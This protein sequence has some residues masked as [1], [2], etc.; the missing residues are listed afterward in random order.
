MN[1]KIGRFELLEQIDVGGYTTVYRATEDMGQGITR[2]A[3]VKA[4]QAW[5]LDDEDQLKRLKREVGVLIEIGDAPNI[6]SVHGMGI[7]EEMG[8]W[9]AM[10]LAGKSLK[11]SLS[12]KP[13]EPDQIRT[14]LS[15]VLHALQWVHGTEPPIL[16]RDLKPQNILRTGPGVWKVAD[17]GLA[18][19]AGAEETMTLATVKYAAPEL[20][21]SALGEE[22]PR[23]DIYA[24]GMIAY[25]MALGRA[26]FQKQFPSV[27]D[28]MAS[29]KDSEGDDR[30]KWMYWHTSMQM[31]LPPITELIEDYPQDLSDLIQKM[32]AK[33]IL[34]RIASA[35]E[36]LEQLGQVSVAKPLAMLDD[37]EDADKG[38]SLMKKLVGALAFLVVIAV[39]GGLMWKFIEGRPSIVFPDG[40]LFV[41]RSGV[42]QVTGRI[43]NF[44][45]TG[46]A[47]VRLKRGRPF[48]VSL[49]GSDGS[50]T[51]D[52]K[53]NELDT[54][55]GYLVVSSQT[56][57]TLA[58][59]PLQVVREAPETVRFELKTKP[60]VA[61]ATVSLRPSGGEQ[62]QITTDALGVANSVLPFGEF[63][64]ELFHPRY[65]PIARMT[66][67]TGIEPEWSDTADLKPRD[68][69]QIVADIQREIDRLMRLMKKKV[70]CPP[71]PPLTPEDEQQVLS[72]VDR[73]RQLA[74]GD[75]DIELFLESVG[76]TVDCEPSSMPVAPPLP[77]DPGAAGSF[78][79]SD[80]VGAL[81]RLLDRVERLIDRKVTCPPGPLSEFE[82][83]VLADTLIEIE[84][85]ALGDLDI[86]LYVDSVRSVVDC[87]P[88]SR[89]PRPEIPESLRQQLIAAAGGASGTSGRG[90]ADGTGGASGAGGTSGQAGYGGAAGRAGVAGAAANAVRNELDSFLN[91]SGQP[92][93][94]MRG[95]ASSADNGRAA[96]DSTIASVLAGMPPNPALVEYL[97]QTLT[98]E[99]FA[100]FIADNVPTG[101]I[102]I[103]ALTEVNKVRI[104]GPMFNTTDLEWMVKRL[105]YGWTR[106]QPEL[107]IDAWAVCRG[108]RQALESGGASGAR[109]DAYLIPDDP[110]MFVQ[111]EKTDSYDSTEAERIASTFT[112]DAGLIW[113]RGYIDAP[114]TELPEA[115][116]AEPE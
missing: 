109:V 100:E 31:V 102:R 115:Q 75:P 32:I 20:L 77:A 54:M 27:Y 116:T 99:Q 68:F 112:V 73:L 14:L 39:V 103:E 64:L 106:I 10:E 51:A 3:A 34:E 65:Q 56:G 86:Q 24:L 53:L 95:G 2:P 19:R 107:S 90:G 16:H 33:P 85:T 8:P 52:V 45:E 18:K 58:R 76:A 43:E 44:P 37:D 67:L 41:G 74:N 81:D 111:Y 6:V 1:K 80:P 40:N 98:L 38:S 5:N 62:I 91:S 114:V 48:T 28:P 50:F 89:P 36:A 25:E 83:K 23:V 79:A 104:S 101:T 94:S 46:R 49:E 97:T 87:D 15:D 11:Y 4:L 78:A 57:T 110:T 96:A 35:D 105:A 93:G 70:T 63:T 59:Q 72:S 29:S 88:S 82:E 60:V 30:P 108:L 66:L 42:I 9:I 21:D 69:S 26:L 55:E 61:G 12:D 47:E 71:N 17:F 7:D 92:G 113:I 13:T 84:A 22:T